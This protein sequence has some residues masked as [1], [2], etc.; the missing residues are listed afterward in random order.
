MSG[1]AGYMVLLSGRDRIDDPYRYLAEAGAFFTAEKHGE[2]G[3]EGMRLMIRKGVLM[4]SPEAPARAPILEDMWVALRRTSF[5][6]DSAEA[7]LRAHSEEV[8]A[9]VQAEWWPI[10]VEK[11]RMISAWLDWLGISRAEVES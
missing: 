1:D 10:R 4:Q 2:E 3:A 5:Q 7:A 9:E 11:D 8:G 6:H